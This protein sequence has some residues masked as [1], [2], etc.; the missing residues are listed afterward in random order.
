VSSLKA[1][2]PLPWRIETGGKKKMSAIVAANGKLVAGSLVC[3]QDPETVAN[4]LQIVIWAN[5]IEYSRLEDTIRNAPLT[6]L[7][8]LNLVA[9]EA[10][11]TRKVW[12]SPE[13]LLRIVQNQIKRYWRK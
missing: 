8:A 5:G 10:A 2:S 12:A 1:M 9:L 4:H 3:E 6:W 7:P 11:I 13:A